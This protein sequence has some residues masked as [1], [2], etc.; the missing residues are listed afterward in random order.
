MESSIAQLLN[1]LV[2]S[3]HGTRLLVVVWLPLLPRLQFSMTFCSFY[4]EN[5]ESHDHATHNINNDYPVISHYEKLPGIPFV[6]KIKENRE[7][8]I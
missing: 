7:A 1:L 4:N 3:L 8:C 2:I 5:K 6:N